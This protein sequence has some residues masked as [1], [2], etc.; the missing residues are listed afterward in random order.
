MLM[1]G[2]KDVLSNN[3]VV[4]WGAGY[5]GK[6]VLEASTELGFTVDSFCDNNQELWGTFFE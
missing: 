3:T 2:K 4:V 5:F 1:D 6:K